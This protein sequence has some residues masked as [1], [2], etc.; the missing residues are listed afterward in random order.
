MRKLIVALALFVGLQAN[1][2]VI[3]VELDA[4][5]VSDVVEVTVL[6]SGFDAFDVL[7]LDLEFDTSL[8]S[9]D[10][11]S[12]GGDLFAAD[13]F[14]TFLSAQSFGAAFSFVSF[15]L[16]AGGDFTIAK[17][18]LTAIG[19][20]VSDFVLTNLLAENFFGAGPIDAVQADVDVVASVS[21]VPAPATLGLFAIVGLALFG[22]RR[23]A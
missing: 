10:E 11:F 16:F 21:E 4:D 18:D 2:G 8:F 12:L 5:N 3:S 20:G 23:K 9:L 14:G 15:D 6:G 13:S 22:F 17:F 7:N 19:T 1:A